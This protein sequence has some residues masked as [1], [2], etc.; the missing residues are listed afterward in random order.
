MPTSPSQKTGNDMPIKGASITR[1]STQVPC[2]T[3]ERTPT[4]TP[5]ATGAMDDSAHFQTC[6]ADGGRLSSAWPL[7]RLAGDHGLPRSPLRARCKKRR[8]WLWIGRSS[9]ICSRSAATVLG[10]RN[11]RACRRQDRR[12]SHAPGRKPRSPSRAP[13]PP[14]SASDGRDIAARLGLERHE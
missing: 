11:R 1:K 13:S 5:K 7:R 12:K 3:A 14:S 6:A 2:R 10:G 8:Y 4:G 9:P